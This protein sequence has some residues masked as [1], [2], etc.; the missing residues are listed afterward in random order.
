M[1]LIGEETTTVRVGM[2]GMRRD[3]KLAGGCVR[4]FVKPGERCGRLVATS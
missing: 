4:T 2:S 1:I 3:V